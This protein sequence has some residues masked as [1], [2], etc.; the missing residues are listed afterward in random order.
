MHIVIEVDGESH[1]MWISRIENHV[2]AET[3]GKTYV[4]VTLPGPGDALTVRLGPSAHTVE[5]TGPSTAAVDGRTL[6][7]R[8]PY[9][10]PRGAPGKHEGEGGGNAQVTAPMP[11]RI[12]AVAVEEGDVVQKGQLLAVL[13]AMKMQN[14]VTAPVAGRVTK[15]HVAQGQVAVRGAPIADLEGTN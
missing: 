12:T 6:S 15:I 8:L 4:M 13:E 9:F 14:E 11:G 1:E 10:N 2:V 5:V 7:F 3:G